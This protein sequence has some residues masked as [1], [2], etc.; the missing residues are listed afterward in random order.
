MDTV[1][2]LVPGNDEGPGKVKVTPVILLTDES[3]QKFGSQKTRHLARLS[4]GKCSVT[5]SGLIDFA[6]NWLEKTERQSTETFITRSRSND[7][8]AV[9]LINTTTAVSLYGICETAALE[10]VLRSAGIPVENVSSFFSSRI[11]IKRNEGDSS[12]LCI[13]PDETDKK[14]IALV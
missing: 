7:R 11:I 14:P 4:V 8:R 10:I 12:Q 13:I 9:R 2:F 1:Q 5:N 3:L 6:R